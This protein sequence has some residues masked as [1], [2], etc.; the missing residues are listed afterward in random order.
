MARA[1]PDES[2]VQTLGPGAAIVVCV[3]AFDFLGDGLR[4]ALDPKLWQRQ[5]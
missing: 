4:T 5:H 3:L 2:A 1:R